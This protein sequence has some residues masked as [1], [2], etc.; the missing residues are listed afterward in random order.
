M[1][2][3]LLYLCIKLLFLC[4][5]QN[6]YYTVPE[7][8]FQKT[9]YDE[10]IFSFYTAELTK[11]SLRNLP[12]CHADS[13]SEYFDQGPC[14]LGWHSSAQGRHQ[15]IHSSLSIDVEK[16]KYK[17]RSNTENPLREVPQLLG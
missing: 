8:K 4:K 10:L 15:R 9:Q 12:V 14:S 3:C 6:I 5:E 2:V 17:G 13:F 1:D 7:T 16:H 11:K